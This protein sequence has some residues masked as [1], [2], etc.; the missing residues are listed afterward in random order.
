MKL[1]QSAGLVAGAVS[2]ALGFAIKAEIEEDIFSTLIKAEE[3]VV[4]DKQAFSG[5]A[6]KAIMYGIEEALNQRKP[7]TKA[8]IDRVSQLCSSFGAFLQLPE[9]EQATLNL[10]SSLHD[11]G[12]IVVADEVLDKSSELAP[13][14]WEMLKRHSEIG[15]KISGLAYGMESDIALII[16]AHHE[17]WDGKGYPQGLKGEDIP[18]LARLLTIVDAFDAM[19]NDR[20]YY[21]AISPTE[22]LRELKFCAGV[23]FDAALVEQFEKYISVDS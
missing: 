6:V 22:A 11:V 19:T 4:R 23:Q 13:V 14:E 8:H 17:S 2:M 12:K 20:P 1:A 16:R 5:D 21:S 18:Y 15:Y 9:R 7:R 10:T 3:Q